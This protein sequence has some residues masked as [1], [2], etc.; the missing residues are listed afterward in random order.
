MFS[1][2]YRLVISLA[3]INFLHER[4]TV[5]VGE[6]AEQAGPMPG[7]ARLIAALPAAICTSIR[8]RLPLAHRVVRQIHGPGLYS[9]RAHFNDT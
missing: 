2:S 1:S 4:S 8:K 9:E 7:R 3:A 5:A 6:G